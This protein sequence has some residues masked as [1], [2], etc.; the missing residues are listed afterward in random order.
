VV[1]GLLDGYEYVY[2]SPGR[3]AWIRLARRSVLEGRDATVAPRI[4]A[5]YRRTRYW[6]LRDDPVTPAEHART[7]RFWLRANELE[8][9]VPF[10]RVW[11]ESYWRR[12]AASR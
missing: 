11:D 5:L 9:F 6:P 3:R 10:A 7:V 1:D 12:A 8:R 4:Y 2:T